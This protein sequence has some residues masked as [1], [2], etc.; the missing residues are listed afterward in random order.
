MSLDTRK[1]A[2]I[3]RYQQVK[4]EKVKLEER[5][6]MYKKSMQEFGAS[7]T[8]ELE[9]RI[10]EAESKLNKLES[11]IVPLLDRVESGLGIK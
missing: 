3:R 8:Q 10:N 5:M 6:S 2:I 1:D 4:E 11:R 7:S 9:E